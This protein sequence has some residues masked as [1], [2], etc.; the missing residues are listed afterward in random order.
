M[1]KLVLI[2]ALIAFSFGHSQAFIGE[3]DNKFQVGANIQ[4]NGTGVNISYDYG[5][6][7]N[8]SIGISSSYALGIP[9]ELKEDQQFESHTYDKASFID[10]YD[11][12]ARFNANIGNILNIDEN[13]DFYPGLNLGLKNFGAHLGARYFFSEGFGLYT[14]F[15]LPIAKYNTDHLSPAEKL[16]N[17]FTVNIGA[18]FNI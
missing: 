7:A 14:E 3:G 13:F 15:N 8:M 5:I 6:G 17:Q 9:G 1:K 10:R 16:H 4:D 11:L 18:S 12:K 2:A